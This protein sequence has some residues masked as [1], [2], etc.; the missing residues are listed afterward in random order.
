[1]ETAPITALAPW[2]ALRA[3]INLGNAVLTNGDFTNPAGISVDLAAELARRLG[4]PLE[5]VLWDAARHSVDAVRDGVA[6]ICFLAV[7]PVRADELA[8][9]GPYV[10]IEG[11]Y[12][13]PEDSPMQS[14]ED[15]DRAGVRIGVKLGSAYDLHLTREIRAAQL[16]RGSDGV[17]VFGDQGLD[18]AAGVRQ[19]IERYAAEHHGVRVLRGSFMQIPQAVAVARRHDEQVV[20]WVREVVDELTAS[21]WVARSL[22]R[23]G[24]DPRLAASV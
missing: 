21:G 22:E 1:M 23:H 8:F 10:R 20:A 19:P 2:G 18:V 15:V 9:T 24:H 4:A 12:L 16:V 6:D 13:V 5:L 3:S 11:S 14:V 7:D 17:D